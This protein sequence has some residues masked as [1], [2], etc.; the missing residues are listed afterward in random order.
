MDT[1]VV[2]SAAMTAHGNCAR[3]IDML[4]DGVFDLC[5]DDRILEEYDSVLRRPQLSIAPGDADVILE[6]IR[7]VATTVA[8]VPLPIELPDPNDAPFLEVAAAF[9]SILVTG[10]A[11]HYPRGARAGVAVLAPQEFVELIR[12]LE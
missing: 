12:G 5:A 11:R 2:V 7:S 1:N 4:V 3:I 6:L 8:A 9:D 10:N